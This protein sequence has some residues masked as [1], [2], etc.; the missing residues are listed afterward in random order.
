MRW[1]IDRFDEIDSTNSYLLFLSGPDAAPG[2]VV[3]TDFQSAGRGRLDRRWEA[4]PG[5][6]LMFSV[7]LPVELARVA[8]RAMALAVSDSC[9]FATGLKW[10]NDIL[11]GDRK[12]AGILAE[13]RSSGPSIGALVVG[14]GL[15][16]RRA[17][18]KGATFIDEWTAEPV[19]ADGLLDSILGALNIWIDQ[20]AEVPAAFLRRCVTIG[21]RVRVESPSGIVEGTATDIAYDGSLLVDVDGHEHRFTVG[22]VIHVR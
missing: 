4:K 14:C 5:D 6:A 10:P 18:V 19:D 13:T 20:P 22:D 21:R 8:T 7:L 9:S 11:V 12:L 2:S 16:L 1:R 17:P 3:V 15:N